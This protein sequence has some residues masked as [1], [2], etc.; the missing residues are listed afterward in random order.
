LVDA[1]S[2]IVAAVRNHEEW[3]GKAC[4]NLIPSENAMS[5]TVRS[6]LSSDLGQ[7]YTSRD[8]FYMGT[9]LTDEIEKQG[10]KLAKQ[11]FGAE[12]ADLRP[13]SGHIAD[14]TILALHTKP[15]DLIMC[16]SASDGGYPGIW[17]KGAPSF[18]KL[19]VA[20][21]PFSKNSM[22][23]EVEKAAELIRKKRPS[24]VIFGAS[25]ILFPHPVK[26]LTQVIHEAG[27][28]IAYDGSHVLGLIAG[29]EFQDPLREGATM[30]FGSTHKTLFGPQGGI[31]LADKEHGEVIKKSIFPAFVDNAHWNRIAA[32]TLALAEM[33]EFGRE[34][35]KQVVKNAQ[36]LAR[37]LSENGFP[38]ACSSLGFTKSHQVYLDYGSFGNGG[39]V[40]GKLEKANIITDCG[41]RLGTCEMTRR[42][43]KQAEMRKIAEFIKRVV[44][45]GEQPAKIKSEVAEFVGEFREIEYCF[46]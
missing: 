40:A 17:R 22:N 35:A 25:L 45:D 4:L 29:G 42:G 13:L 18:L 36:A 8:K 28:H 12:T 32:L 5:P 27:A 31:I 20:E 24:M 34:Y 9:R 11:V 33:K 14:L 19:K 16:I 10:E 30:L 38:V 15:N 37:A 41:V 23:I 43:M 46:N 6:V 44:K 1:V 3:R 7:R 39:R 26:A 2:E 21:L